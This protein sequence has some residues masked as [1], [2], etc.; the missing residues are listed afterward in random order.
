MR[1]REFITIYGNAAI[2]FL[3]GVLA[4]AVIGG[5]DFW[6]LPMPV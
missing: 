6:L 1:R 4:M 3:L 2:G 5:V